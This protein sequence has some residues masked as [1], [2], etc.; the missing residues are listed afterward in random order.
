MKVNE[1]V[2]IVSVFILLISI[3]LV[4][5]V[6]ADDEK[7]C[8]VGTDRKFS[9]TNTDGVGCSK[10]DESSGDT[11]DQSRGLIRPGCSLGEHFTN[12]LKGALGV[13]RIAGLI[14]VVV[15]TIID[16]I[17]SLANG[18]AQAQ[19]QPF[20]TKLLKRIA[21]AIGI[22]VVP[23]LIMWILGLL[24]MTDCGVVTDNTSSTTTTTTTA[25]TS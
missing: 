11:C 22:V 17:K 24:G 20:F 1:L 12:D 6:Y 25:A 4:S 19:I 8:C 10:M 14:L 21:A 18:D 2:K 15:M 23:L 13:F 9:V 5:P 7:Y 3:F 16:A